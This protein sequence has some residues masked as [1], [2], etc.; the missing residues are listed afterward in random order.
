MSHLMRVV[1]FRP[2][3]LDDTKLLDKDYINAQITFYSSLLPYSKPYV[4]SYTTNT[5]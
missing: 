4:T 5:I 3:T 1:P 2:D